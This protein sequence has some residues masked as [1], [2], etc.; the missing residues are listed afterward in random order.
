MNPSLILMTQYWLH[1][2][3][4]EVLVWYPRNRMVTTQGPQVLQHLRPFITPRIHPRC[5]SRI[6]LLYQILRFLVILKSVYPARPPIHL[7]SKYRLR[8]GHIFHYLLHLSHSPH[9]LQLSR[10][11]HRPR[12]YYFHCLHRVIYLHQL[13]PFR[14]L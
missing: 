14:R 13:F 7:N 2:V 11:H 1:L 8:I 4:N 6:A 9:P 10:I 12:T 3:D 5:L